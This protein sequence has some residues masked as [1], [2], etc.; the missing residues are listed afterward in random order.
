VLADVFVIA[1]AIKVNNLV[2]TSGQ[3][4]VIPETGKWMERAG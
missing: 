3:I 1:Q 4:P 2:Y